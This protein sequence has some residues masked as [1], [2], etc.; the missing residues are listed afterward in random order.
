MGRRSVRSGRRDGATIRDAG[1]RP[2]AHARPVSLKPSIEG[3]SWK[4][5]EG[6]ERDAGAG[7]GH[8]KLPRSGLVQRLIMERQARPEGPTEG[9]LRTPLPHM[10][11][12]GNDP[13]QGEVSCTRATS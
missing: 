5:G 3:S 13:T 7:R 1:S 6:V 2:R 11:T 10:Q 9:K 8:K 12:H 4:A